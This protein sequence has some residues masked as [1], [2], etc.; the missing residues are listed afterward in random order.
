MKLREA[1]ESEKERHESEEAILDSQLQDLKTTLERTRRELEEARTEYSA[2]RENAEFAER[3]QE[4]LETEKHELAQEVDILLGER[5]GAGT[6]DLQQQLEAAENDVQELQAELVETQRKLTDAQN[7]AASP[8]RNDQEG[9]QKVHEEMRNLRQ[10]KKNLE[11]RLESANHESRKLQST[12]AAA[13]AESEEYQG[14]IKRMQSQADDTFRLDQ[15][16]IDLRTSK[17]RLEAEL[18]RLRDEHERLL[19]RNKTMEHDLGTLES[20]T[21]SQQA[22]L[23]SEIED[24][25][26]QLANRSIGKSRD[27]H[28]SKQTITILEARVEELQQALSARPGTND[29]DEVTDVLRKEVASSRDRE[30]GF[31]RRE[32]SQKDSIR[33]LKTKVT[34]LERQLHEAEIAK[35]SAESPQSSVS[36]SARKN[37]LAEL[38]RELEN[39]QQQ[40]R[41]SRKKSR[42]EQRA[43]QQRVTEAERKAQDEIDKLEQ[44]R[45]QIETE[46]STL[47]HEYQGLQLKSGSATQTI[48]R[49]RTRIASLEQ[50]FHA[51]R[52]NATAD[53]TIAEERA[54]LHEMLKDA[55]LQAEDLQIQL[56]AREASLGTA[57]VKEKE[58][59]T[60]L[61]RV[62]EERTS[63]THKAGALAAELGSLQTRHERMLDTIASQQREWDEERNVMMKGVRFANMDTSSL[64]EGREG[65]R[66]MQKRHS[67][68]LKGLAKQIQWLRAKCKREE[69][70]RSGLVLEKQ[71]LMLQVSMFEAW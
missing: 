3:E 66:D 46:L 41:D 15:E 30:N 19:K 18:D 45:E 38:Q 36:G 63:Q 51:H 20:G 62:R 16:R 6:E 23:R 34:R 24:L 60:Q 71:Y 1:F 40:L 27:L 10:E 59:R 57:S 26:D 67:A 49:L 22:R 52:Q 42:E 4:R 11:E 32:A 25:K 35:L 44:Q 53:N 29:D 31:I 64:N 37:E 33:D 13:E 43:L 17:M 70:F 5:E 12:L 9:G 65:R 21:S 7:A 61:R 69:G 28:A 50:D 8:R 55:K 54:D 14:K 58:L 47:R 2:A 39:A 48:T 68:E 56:T